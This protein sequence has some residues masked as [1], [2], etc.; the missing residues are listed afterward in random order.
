M[1][2]GSQLAAAG[3]VETLPT[4]DAALWVAAVV[5]YGVGDA[6]TTALGAR[7]PGLREGSPL[8]RGLLGPHPSLPAFGAFKAVVLV[9]FSGAYLALDPPAA[10]A[11]PLALAVVGTVATLSNLRKLRRTPTEPA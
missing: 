1:V 2:A 7:R 5:A 4:L 3:P 11:V 6:V 8:V 10:T 9:A